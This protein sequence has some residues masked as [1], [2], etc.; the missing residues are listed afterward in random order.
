MTM[1]QSPFSEL[2]IANP[3]NFDA[4]SCSNP[5]MYLSNLLS[6]EISVLSYCKMALTT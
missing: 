2:K 1:K 3:F 5:S 6:A 4:V